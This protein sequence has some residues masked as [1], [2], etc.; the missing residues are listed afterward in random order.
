MHSFPLFSSSLFLHSVFRVPDCVGGTALHATSSHY[1]L[2]DFV[3]LWVC[4][5]VPS[6]FIFSFAHISFRVLFGLMSYGARQFLLCSRFTSFLFSYP[7]LLFSP[8][9]I[10]PPRL[11]SIILGFSFLHD[12]M[13]DCIGGVGITRCISGFIED[14]M[15][16]PR[17]WP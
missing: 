7:R 11:F 17:L 3:V 4:S 12:G 6:F 14:Y 16:L 9:F 13:R 1:L 2:R 15:Y 10:F 5:L 8:L